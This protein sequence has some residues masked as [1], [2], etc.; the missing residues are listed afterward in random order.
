MNDE[1]A[2]YEAPA[3][4]EIGGFSELTQLVRNGNWADSIWGYYWD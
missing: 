4:A 2:P 1:K 3:F